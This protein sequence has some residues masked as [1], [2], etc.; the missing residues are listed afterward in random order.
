MRAA[1][2]RDRREAGLRMSAATILDALM[3]RYSAPAYAFLPEMRA[4]T[5]YSRTRSAD[6]IAMSLY[7]SRGLD[8]SGFEIKV[9]R[10]DWMRELKDP[11]KA[12]EICKSCD[13]WWV[14]APAMSSTGPRA[15]PIVRLEDLPPTWG[16]MLLDGDKLKVEKNAPK[17][18][19]KPLD[20][21]FCASMM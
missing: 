7:P 15:T 16:L 21:L 5:G 8:V 11:D 3:K 6:G 17:L 4:G 12:E 20:K 14:V 13:Y 1:R 2:D 9:S 18:E 10:S 19:A